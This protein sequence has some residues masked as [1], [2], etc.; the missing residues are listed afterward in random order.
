[1]RKFI[2]FIFVLSL[3]S[4]STEIKKPDKPV[5]AV[6][7]LPQKYLVSSIADTLVEVVVMVPPGASPATWEAKPAQ[8]KM[9]SYADAYFRIGHIGFEKAWMEKIT[10]LNENMRIFD[11]SADLELL[12]V[13]Y[14]HDDHNHTGTDPHTWMSP[15]R[16]EQM[17]RKV[18]G[19][20][21]VLYPEHKD[22]FRNNY[23]VLL[24]EIKLV[25][26]YASKQLSDHGGKAFLIFHPSLS[27]LADDYNLVQISIEYEGKEP[28]PAHM[29]DIIDRARSRGIRTIFVQQ[30][31]DQRNAGIIAE[32]L[33][34]SIIRLNPLSED[35]ANEIRSITSTLNKTLR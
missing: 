13:N 10:D 20:L 17:A 21:S 5:I 32:E 29:K 27:Y 25:A 18:Y 8:M 11:L 3:I 30:E 14:K 15:A 2:L 12:T 19:D 22:Q 4:C 6:S 23:K 35:W 1:M 7:I 34:G 26:R 28:S 31:F 16:M 33:A 24:H 9:L